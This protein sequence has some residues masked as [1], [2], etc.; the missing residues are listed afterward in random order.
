M[1]GLPRRGFKTRPIIY[2][3]TARGKPDSLHLSATR[4]PRISPGMSQASIA[5]MELSQT[6]FA[7]KFGF[8]LDF[9]SKLG[10][11][12]PAGRACAHPSCRYCKESCRYCKEPQGGRGGPR[13]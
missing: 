12:S 6:Q 7:V 9:D 5:S 4:M 11:G 1:I 8:S 13:L 10:T 3:A 2:E